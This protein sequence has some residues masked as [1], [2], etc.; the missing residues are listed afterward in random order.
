[1]ILRQMSV[2]AI[3]LLALAFYSIGLAQAPARAT[4]QIL[5]AGSKSCEV[6]STEAGGALRTSNVEWVLGYVTSVSQERAMR[7]AAGED[8]KPLE[9]TDAK[10]IVSF[11]DKYC[12]DRPSRPVADAAHTLLTRLGHQWPTPPPPPKREYR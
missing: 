7:I 4:F 9:R 5:G 2:P 8:L 12:E 10:A 3:L 6:W 11:I 1:V